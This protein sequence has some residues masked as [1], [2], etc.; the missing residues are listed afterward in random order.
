MSLQTLFS[1][2]RHRVG[3]SFPA[4]LGI[5]AMLAV[6][7]VVAYAAFASPESAERA[8]IVLQG[9]EIILLTLCSGII[10]GTVHWIGTYREE[11]VHAARP[12][13][14]NTAAA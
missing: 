2:F 10:A 5:G 3:L 4:S 11:L 9:A 8:Q 7:L 1:P 13:S 12:R 6:L 14:R